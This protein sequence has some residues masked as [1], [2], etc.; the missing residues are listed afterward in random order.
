[1]T[2]REIVESKLNDNFIILSSKDD[3]VVIT[4]KVKDGLSIDLVKLQNSPTIQVCVENRNNGKK[5]ENYDAD[6]EN[7]EEMIQVIESAISMFDTASDVFEIKFN[8]TAE[9]TED[10]VNLPDSSVVST[11]EV[12]EEEHNDNGSD[13]P[14]N[15]KVIHHLEEANAL[16]KNKLGTLE[17]EIQNKIIEDIYLEIEELCRELAAVEVE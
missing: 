17:T 6:Y 14:E 3:E 4:K 8:D 13:M 15:E 16:L 1:M 5:I 11:E 9:T 2:F 10:I 7:E 12:S